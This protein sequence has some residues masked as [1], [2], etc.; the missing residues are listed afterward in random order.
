LTFVKRDQR[1]G[2][3][4]YIVRNFDYEVNLVETVFKCH[5]NDSKARKAM[6]I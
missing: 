6:E 2:T 4:N 3:T 5:S 1:S